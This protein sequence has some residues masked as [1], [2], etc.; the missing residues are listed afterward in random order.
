MNIK[1]INE[2]LKEDFLNR[3]MNIEEVAKEIF[4]SGF[5]PYIPNKKQALDF[6]G[7]N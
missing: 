4:E 6:I 5:Y 1:T 2:S 3:K 7:V